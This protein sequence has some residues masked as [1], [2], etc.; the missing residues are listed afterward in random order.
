MGEGRQAHVSHR[1][2]LNPPGD[3]RH[4]LAA[5]HRFIEGQGSLLHPGSSA[6]LPLLRGS[7]ATH[8]VMCHRAGMTH[9]RNPQQVKIPPL[10]GSFRLSN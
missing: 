5:G 2:P 8:L 6:T 1:S 9:L 3:N 7:C 10:K 4:G